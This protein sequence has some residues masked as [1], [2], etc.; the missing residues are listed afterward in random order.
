[1]LSAEPRVLADGKTVLV[2]TFNCGLYL[3]DSLTS[4]TPSARLVSS[5][6]RKDGTSCA[7]PVIAGHYYLVTV[8]AWNA[9]VS[10]DISDPAAP[11]DVSRITLGRTDVPHWLAMAPDKRRVVVTGYQGMQHCVVIARFDSTSGQ[12][13]LDER[14]REDSASEPGFCMDNK[15]WPHGG[16]AKGIPHGAVFS[17]P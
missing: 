15:T 3:L 13:T 5:F 4:A 10:L 6:P 16:S 17:R 11:K 12:L 7:I 2:S 1:M 8:P 9:V 14:F